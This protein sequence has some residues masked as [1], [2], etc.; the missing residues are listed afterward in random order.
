MKRGYTWLAVAAVAALGLAG[1]SAP[2]DTGTS[3]SH[4][5]EWWAPNWDE[6]DANQLIAEY[7]KDHPDVKVKLVVT[8]WDTM[9]N[10]IKVALDSGQTPDVITELISRIPVY[11]AADQL[12]DVSGWFDDAMPKDDFIPS[13]V[14]AVSRDGGIYAVPF[15][16]DA[17]SMIYNKDLFEKAGITEPPTTW[18]ELEADAKKLK[19][20]GVSA[21]GWPFGNDNNTAVRWLN[22]YYTFGGTIAE[23]GKLDEKASLQALEQLSWGFSDEI[24]TPSSLEADNTQLQNLLM[25]G[26]IAFYFEGAYAIDPIKK[27]GINVGTAMWPGVDGPAKVSADGFALMVPKK[28][29][30]SAEVR[31]FVQFISSPD[32]QALMTDTFPARISATQNKKFSDPL[33]QPFLEQ[34]TKDAFPSPSFQGWQEMIP[35]VFQAVQSVALGSKTPEQANADIVAQAKTSLSK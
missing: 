23:G 9:A 8:T 13:A 3:G 33:F 18:S 17:G 6:S 11:A 5:I 30:D 12:A 20:S 26:Q 7:Q 1:C 2:S 27:A 10:Q 14:D 22:A 28:S 19:A 35:V 32:A 29:G 16:W 31:D 34:Q 24:V 21:Y 25:N 15:R 4:Q